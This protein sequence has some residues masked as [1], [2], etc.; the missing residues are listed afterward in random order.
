M[1]IDWCRMAAQMADKAHGVDAPY[2]GV[3]PAFVSSSTLFNPE[4]C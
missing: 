2:I 3:D 4:V 1:Y